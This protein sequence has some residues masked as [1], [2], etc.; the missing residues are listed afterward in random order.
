LMDHIRGLSFGNG[1]IFGIRFASVLGQQKRR[2][3]EG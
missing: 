2:P 1:I 3:V